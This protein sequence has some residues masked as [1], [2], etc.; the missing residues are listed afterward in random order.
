LWAASDVYVRCDTVFPVLTS[1]YNSMTLRI[2]PRNILLPIRILIVDDSPLVRRG[3]RG[4]I[5]NNTDW[6]ICGEADDGQS[7][8][9]MVSRLKPDLVILDLSMPIMNGLDAARTISRISP[10][11]HMVMFTMLDC[12]DLLKSSAEAVGIR[13]IFSKTHGFSDQVLDKIRSLVAA[14]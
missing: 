7:A 13:H 10:E 1:R 4:C 6:E 12:N 9:E 11:T 8:V 14:A 2:V 5:Q 3:I